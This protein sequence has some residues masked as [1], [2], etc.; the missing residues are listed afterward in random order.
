MNEL[1][2]IIGLTLATVL[3]QTLLTRGDNAVSSPQQLHH[4]EDWYLLQHRLSRP[5]GY[6]PLSRQRN[7]SNSVIYL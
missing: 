7:N 4:S 6:Q 5:N 3:P 2:L 1:A